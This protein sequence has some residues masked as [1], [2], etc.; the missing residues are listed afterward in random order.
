MN[1]TVLAMAFLVAFIRGLPL[2]YVFPVDPIYA[3]GN[4][5][6]GFIGL[7]LMF[8]GLHWIYTKIRGK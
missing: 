4:G 2:I 3:V 5:V 1:R 7:L 8:S 6:G